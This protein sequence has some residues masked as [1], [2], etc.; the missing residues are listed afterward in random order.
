MKTQ[1]TWIWISDKPRCICQVQVCPVHSLGH[2]CTKPLFTVDLKFRCDRTSCI[3]SGT[4][5]SVQW[6]PIFLV[7]GTHF[8]E[9]SLSTDWKVGRDGFR[10]IHAHLLFIL[11]LW[12]LHLFHLGSPGIRSQRLGTTGVGESWGCYC[13]WKWG[14]GSVQAPREQSQDISSC[15]QS[16]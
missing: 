2:T 5:L 4:C 11:F 6:S 10:M 14:V 9:D 7:P 15:S 12:L 1:N 13:A 8:M 16:S 3:L